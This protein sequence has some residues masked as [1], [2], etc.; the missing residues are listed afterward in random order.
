M[1]IKKL[2]KYEV[3]ERL[4]R[5]GMAEVYKAYHASLNRHVA[6]KILHSFLAEDQE[7]AARF[8]REAQNIARL[9]HPHIVQVYDYEFDEASESYYMVMELIA[10]KTLKD[11]L[12]ELEASRQKMPLEEA[13][14]ITRESASALAYAHRAGMIHR[15]VKPA[16]LLLDSDDNE[17]VVLTDFGIA[18]IVKGSQFTVSGGL[19]GTPAYM[20]PEQGM[21]ETG[22]ERSDLYSLGVILYQMVTGR[23]PYDAETPL[24]LI[25]CH[26]ND[27]IPS[28][29]ELNPR[30]PK[31]IDHVIR[32]L[33]AKE[34]D[35]RYASA[36]AL[37]ADIRRIEEKLYQPDTNETPVQLTPVPREKARGSLGDSP[38]IPFKQLG[39]R[40]TEETQRLPPIVASS[41]GRSSG[42][43]GGGII[44]LLGL[45]ILLSLAGGGYVLGAQSGMF[46]AVAFLASPTP[47]ATPEPTDTPIP[48]DTSTPTPPPTDTPTATITP[49]LTETVIASPTPTETGTATPTITPTP[50]DTPTPTLTPNATQT[51]IAE[52]TATFAACTFDYAIIDQTPRDGIE[53]GFYTVNSAYTRRI[54]LLNT[55]TCDWERNTSMSFVEGEDFN[56]GPRVFIREEVGVGEEVEVLFEGT[57]PSSGSVQPFAGRWQLRTPG[58]IPI[59]ESFVISVQVFDPGT[60][61]P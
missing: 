44:W 5:G 38:T 29:R 39:T 9:K 32:K 4:G 13:L 26:M 17:R 21:G 46:P 10:E 12:L 18:K 20:A 51:R 57:L 49:T 28:A 24:A 37:I 22:D 58:Q 61:G 59:G 33:L 6:I 34:P 30:L 1:T 15:D 48:T 8:E 36:D 16:N 43:D 60:D 3:I 55:G 35:T 27:P 7:F 42:G 47:S 11:R 45:L 14:R 40:R 31:A 52:R 54:T 41:G 25:L 23:L 53:G 56:A 19:V 50:T 2:G